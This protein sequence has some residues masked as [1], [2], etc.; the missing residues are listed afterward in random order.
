[1]SSFLFWR[2][3]TAP[4][5][6]AYRQAMMDVV[7]EMLA[8]AQKNIEQ[9]AQ[10]KAAQEREAK[11]LN[12][13]AEATQC[14]QQATQSEA[15]ARE[16]EEQAE[17]LEA[18][19]IL[20]ETMDSNLD[21][22]VV[23]ALVK[24]AKQGM[25][26]FTLLMDEDPSIREH[27]KEYFT[28]NLLGEGRVVPP[29]HEFYQWLLS[30]ENPLKQLD[31]YDFFHDLYS[32]RDILLTELAE[33][34][35]AAETS[36]E[37]LAEARENERVAAE[38]AAEARR[39]LLAEIERQET[40]NDNE[41]AFLEEARALLAD[42]EADERVEE[43]KSEEQPTQ[44]H[45]DATDTPEAM[46]RN[47]EVHRA[48]AEVARAHARKYRKLELDIERAQSRDVTRVARMLADEQWQDGLISESEY[49]SRRA[50]IAEAEDL[51]RK[52]DDALRLRDEARSRLKKVCWA[53]A[54]AA[55]I[56]LILIFK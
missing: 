9:E 20:V 51:W 56:A 26:V 23:E 47:A 46:R 55:L 2:R 28:G 31:L 22:Q 19:K 52:A 17:S 40:L 33:A 30:N 3:K 32:R 10:T 11:A 4:P 24:Y 29:Q 49:K 18:L 37:K 5:E 38:K 7:A 48:K 53:V 42:N 36:R 25:P 27:A 6:V 21:A 1:M 15:Q 44:E 13:E 45:L 41:R 39:E 50:D 14:E 16:A 8:T 34:Q 54:I 43:D 12:L 35:D